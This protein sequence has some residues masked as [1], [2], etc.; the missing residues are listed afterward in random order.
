MTSIP[1]PRRHTRTVKVHTAPLTFDV[2]AGRFTPGKEPRYILG[3]GGGP[4][5]GLEGLGKQEIP[6]PGRVSNSGPPNP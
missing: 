6:R 1:T 3:G 5:A 4:R 2:R